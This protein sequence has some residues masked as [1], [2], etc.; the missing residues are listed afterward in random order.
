[1][2][3]YLGTSPVSRVHSQ[4]VSRVCCALASVVRALCEHS[5][6]A[7]YVT[8]FLQIDLGRPTRS[9]RAMRAMRADGGVVFQPDVKARSSL[10]N[11]ETTR[12]SIDMLTRNAE[13]AI[14]QAGMTSSKATANRQ[15]LP[16]AARPFRINRRC[17]TC[18][19][20]LTS[21]S[22]ELSLLHAQVQAGRRCRLSS[23][24]QHS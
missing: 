15:I 3:R 22:S 12:Y 19:C 5:P 10:K 14:E 24:A 18:C 9:M 17:H 8:R 23:A 4:G 21:P 6:T 2:I 11:V 20:G 16:R 13:P 7:P 1:M